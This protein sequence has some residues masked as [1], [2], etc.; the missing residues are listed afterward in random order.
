MA[1]PRLFRLYVISKSIV[2]NTLVV[3]A[4]DELGTRE[5]KVKGVNWVSGEVPPASFHAM[6]KIRYTARPVPANVIP[7]QDGWV[8]VQ[9]ESPAAGR[10]PWSSSG[11]LYWG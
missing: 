2:E 11:I 3:G 5:L 1:S 8:E 10:Y 9:F 7:L 4:E 6:V